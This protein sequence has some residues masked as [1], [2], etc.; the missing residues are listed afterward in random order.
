MDDLQDWDIGQSS[1]HPP[2]WGPRWALLI[3]TVEVVP[4]LNLGGPIWPL[5][6]RTEWQVQIQLE[7]QQ[8]RGRQV[9]G[10]WRQSQATQ[11]H[12]STHFRAPGPPPLTPGNPE[13]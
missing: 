9:C 1:F 5:L 10:R 13:G 8:E 6:A 11:A 3:V 2:R 4:G 7:Q 12:L